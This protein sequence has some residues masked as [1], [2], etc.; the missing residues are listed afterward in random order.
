[1]NVEVAAA[2]YAPQGRVALGFA[3]GKMGGDPVYAAVLARMPAEG[4]LLDVGCGEGYLLALAAEAH[5]GLRLVGLD[6]DEGRLG[7]AKQALTDRAPA[8]TSE[9]A[10]T[11][12]L[13]QAD[14]IACLDV[15]HYQPADQ[16]DELIAKLA[17]ALRPGGQLW[18]RDA[19]ADAGWRSTLTTWSERFAVA[20]GR[21][22]GDG[23]FLRPRGELPAAMAACGLRVESVDCSEGT[24]FANVLHV[25]HAP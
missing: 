22:R 9:D 5:P 16:Q 23:V 12:T 2:R 10:R 21:H 25:G 15:L 13:P 8:L 4:T 11:A 3:K 7:S 19:A 17:G 24:P 14:A 6:H 18:I 20:V 1:M